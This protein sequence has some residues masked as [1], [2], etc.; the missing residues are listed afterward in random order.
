MKSHAYSVTQ[1]YIPAT[2]SLIERRPRTL[3]HGDTFAMF[4]HYGDLSGGA[5][6]PEG[7]YHQ[8]TR[9]LSLLH[10]EINGRKPLLLS[11]TVQKNNALLRVDLTNPDIFLENELLLA[12][13]TVHLLRSKYVWQSAC[14]ETIVLRNYANRLESVTLDLEFDA[15]FLDMF[16]VRGH[17][18]AQ[19]GITE[20]A[21]VDGRRV[22]LRYTGLDARVRTT[23][24]LFDPAPDEVSVEHVQWRIRLAPKETRALFFT[25]VCGEPAQT[26]AGFLANL[27]HAQR[28][29]VRASRRHA[30][31]RTSNEIFNE[32]LCRSTADLVMLTTE[33]AYGPYPYAGVPW[34]S[35]PFGR[36]GIITA[37]QMLPFDPELA[38]GVL[39][40]LAATQAREH[41][42]A[43]DAEPGKILH[44]MRGGE[45]AALR[46]VPFGMYYGSVD[47]TPLFVLLAG[48]YFE[49]TADLAT[50]SSL[51]PNI[52]AALAW[53]DRYGDAYGDGFVEYLRKSADG[54]ANQGWKDS[55]DSVFHADGS[56][57]R[58]AIRLCE[59][60]AYVYAAKK[61]AARLAHLMGEP[62]LAERLA[63]QAAALREQFEARFWMEDRGFYAL[64]LDGEK[65]PCRVLASN[66]GHALFCGIASAEHAGRVASKLMSREFFCGW[67][68]RTVGST[69][70][71]YNPMSYHNGSVWPHDNALIA[72]GLAR[73]GHTREAV[74]LLGA[75]FDASTHIDLRRLPELFCGVQRKP[76]RSPT[77]YP[78][79]CSPQAWASAAPFALL[80]A[81]LGLEV[82]AASSTLRF[83]HPMLPAFLD[84][85]ELRNVRM[86]A[87]MIDV[88][89]HRRGDGVSA[90]VLDKHGAAS[91]EVLL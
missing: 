52:C 53:I 89:V 22:E 23:V 71:R 55:E 21:L 36:D 67:G 81:A 90:V 2:S 29:R 75:L 37:I 85:V 6:S 80:S 7:L 61:H 40:L 15:D 68:I 91:V 73:Y 79:A 34:F 31:V 43:R 63:V 38:R 35:T 87:S 9:Y 17:A 13:D 54:L 32:L 19:R 1:F 44:E 12:K 47:S 14:Y 74:T 65:R 3:K 83:R 27:R 78:V 26:S 57:A 66:A 46:E 50:I 84:E 39:A 48:L 49:R 24:L 51:W 41:D 42:A 62:A 30:A 58:G 18:R 56:L 10:M 25:V 33:T 4:D 76:E 28:A 86:G 82:D 5:F 64:A 60:Q 20:K 8:D 11:S 88:A 45:M 77:F 69:E 72:L 16:E 59:V 70:A